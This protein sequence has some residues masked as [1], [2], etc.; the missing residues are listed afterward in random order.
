MAPVKPAPRRGAMGDTGPAWGG[1]APADNQRWEMSP[2]SLAFPD[3]PS[4]IAIPMRAPIPSP[5]ANSL[6]PG[7]RL[8]NLVNERAS[9]GVRELFNRTRQ[10]SSEEHENLNLRVTMLAGSYPLMPPL[11]NEREHGFIVYLARQERHIAEQQQSDDL[12]PSAELRH[13][14]VLTHHLVKL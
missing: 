9:T 2:L 13:E 1:P 4:L 12:A 10:A 11:S 6:S 8:V 14:W 3:A 7:V 5:L